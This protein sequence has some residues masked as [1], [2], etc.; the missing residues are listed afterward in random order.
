[1]RK[2]DV[3]N[4]KH[5]KRKVHKTSDISAE[6]RAEKIHQ[7]KR[8]TK[9]SKNKKNGGKREVKNSGQPLQEGE[10]TKKAKGL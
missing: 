2:L 5:D 8:W 1:L 6:R 9:I 4:A 3:S 10:K 7:E